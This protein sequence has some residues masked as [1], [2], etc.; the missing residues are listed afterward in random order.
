VLL[1]ALGLA[2]AC[3]TASGCVGGALHSGVVL[4]T[5]VMGLAGWPYIA[6]LVRAQTVVLRERE[7]VAA[8]RCAGASHAAVLRRDIL[9]NLVG[10]VA[11]WAAFSVPTNMLFEAGLAFLGLGVP[12]PT[13]SWGSMLADSAATFDSA[14][15]YFVAPT[16]AIAF[17]AIAFNLVA[18]ALRDAMDPRR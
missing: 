6:R 11:V 13:A 2:A 4:V 9:P 5:I 16:A 15:W 3:S 1:L 10:P 18:D 12:E 17:T 14:W 8:G 7:F